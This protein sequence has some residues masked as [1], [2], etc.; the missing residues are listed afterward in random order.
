[1]GTD[2]D[3]LCSYAILSPIPVLNSLPDPKFLTRYRSRS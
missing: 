3:P 1:M 2:P